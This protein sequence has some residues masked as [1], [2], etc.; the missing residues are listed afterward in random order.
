MSRSMSTVRGH[1]VAVLTFAC[2]GR[3]EMFNLLTSSLHPFP[4]T[5]SDAPVS[6]NPLTAYSA[7][8]TSAYGRGSFLSL[9]CDPIAVTICSSFRLSLFSL[10][11]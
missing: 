8:S 4:S 6:S 10:F 2:I 11:P 7:T 5:L 1:A 9:S 3:H